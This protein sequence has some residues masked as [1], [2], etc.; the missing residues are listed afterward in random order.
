MVLESIHGKM[1]PSIKETMSMAKNKEME[2]FITLLESNMSECGQMENSKDKEKLS[3]KK[4]KFKNK[5]SGKMELFKE[6]YKVLKNNKQNL[7]NN[8][9]KRHRLVLTT[10]YFFI[11]FFS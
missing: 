8:L 7:S 9:F 3:L 1:D 11:Q 4:E 10:L 6:K 5:E 2:S